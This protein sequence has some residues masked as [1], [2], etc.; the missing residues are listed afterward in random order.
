[1]TLSHH[2][3]VSLFGRHA[4]TVCFSNWMGP[5]CVGAAQQDRGTSPLCI[6]CLFLIRKQYDKI[7]HIRHP[8]NMMMRVTCFSFMDYTGSFSARRSAKA[9]TGD[10]SRRK[11]NE[12]AFRHILYEDISL[13]LPFFEPLFPA[14]VPIKTFELWRKVGGHHATSS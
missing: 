12:H 5:G 8:R 13:G 10:L 4:A 7:K 2:D 11:Y 6:Q 3:E 14:V 1:M 9:G